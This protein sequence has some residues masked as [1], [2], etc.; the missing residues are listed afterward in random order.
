[1]RGRNGGGGSAAWLLALALL[2][3]LPAMALWKLQGRWGDMLWLAA[4]PSVLSFA[5]YAWDKRQAVQ[6][7]ARVAEFQLLLLD[8]LGGWPG[9]FLAQRWLRHKT[10]KVG[11]QFAFWL[12]VTGEEAA[13]A[14]WL[15]S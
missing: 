10:S 1:M 11:F 6:N 5:Q 2:L 12:V 8:V 3:I 4:V 9:G 15:W 7:G 13:L 14:L